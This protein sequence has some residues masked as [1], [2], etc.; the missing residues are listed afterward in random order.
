MNYLI[1]NGRV[2]AK[3]DGPFLSWVT[4]DDETFEVGATGYVDGKFIRD[5]DLPETDESK[6][7]KLLLKLVAPVAPEDVALHEELVTNM[8]AK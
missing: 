6:A 8:E 3:A 1:S 5:S 7:I 4:D 2:V